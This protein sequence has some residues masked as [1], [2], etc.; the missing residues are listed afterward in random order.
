[1]SLKASFSPMWVSLSNKYLNGIEMRRWY[2]I[3]IAG[4]SYLYQNMIVICLLI[5]LITGAFVCNQNTRS[6]YPWAGVFLCA[7]VQIVGSIS[8][9]TLARK[10]Q[11]DG[12]SLL[13]EASQ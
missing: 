6:N 4:S 13:W 10:H 1:M 8:I 2:V 9:I 5:I 11:S 7:L 12:H 3:P